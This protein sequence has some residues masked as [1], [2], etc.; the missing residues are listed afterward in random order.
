MCSGFIMF[1]VVLFVFCLF[2]YYYVSFPVIGLDIQDDLGRHEVGFVEDTFKDP[3]N[4]GKGCRFKAK[5]SINKVS[6]LIYRWVSA[7]KM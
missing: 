4:E 7:R 5:F 3:I 6:Q 1:I 2:I